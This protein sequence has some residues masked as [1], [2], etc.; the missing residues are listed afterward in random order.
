[1]PEALIG[2]LMFLL[3]LCGALFAHRFNSQHDKFWARATSK[4]E[5]E[6]RQFRTATPITRVVFGIA[7]V[8]G[9]I[10]MLTNITA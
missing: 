2:L 6:M 7:A 5:E 10:F 4:S 9:L 3:G 1:M 8:A